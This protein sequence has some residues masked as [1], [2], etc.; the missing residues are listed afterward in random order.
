M[1]PKLRKVSE[2]SPFHLI[3]KSFAFFL[4]GRLVPNLVNV[5]ETIR[6]FESKVLRRERE[7][8]G[9]VSMREE[10]MLTNEN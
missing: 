3:S 8:V 10:L 2:V 4:E 5:K 7:E 9:V 1:F 6:G